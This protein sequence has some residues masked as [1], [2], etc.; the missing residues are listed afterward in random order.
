M[1]RTSH[2]QLNAAFALGMAVL[3]SSCSSLY[4]SRSTSF[5]ISGIFPEKKENG[6]VLKIAAVQN[7][8]KVE[9]WIGENNWL[10][11]SI[12]DTSINT[13]QLDDL[14]S[15]P[16]VSKMHF[17]R[18]AGSVQVTLQLNQQFD[19]V[20]VLSYPDEY[21]TYVVLYQFK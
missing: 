11:V 2:L 12:P 19:H 3:L 16:I 17:F 5:N 4:T 21:N 8:G 13:S 20:G 10:Y 9:A 1:M 18:Y 7:I 14:L 15:C 6:Y